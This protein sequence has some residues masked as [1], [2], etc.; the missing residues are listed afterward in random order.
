MAVINPSE[1]KLAKCTLCTVEG[2]EFM[3]YC[4]DKDFNFLQCILQLF[5]DGLMDK[6][7]AFKILLFLFKAL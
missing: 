7:L 2:T 4:V 5:L 3:K 6:A 1:R